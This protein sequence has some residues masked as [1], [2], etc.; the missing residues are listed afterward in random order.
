MKMKDFARY[1]KIKMFEILSRAFGVDTGE[2]TPSLKIKRKVV[3]KKY[4]AAIERIYA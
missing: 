3:V 2:L 1:E 4:A